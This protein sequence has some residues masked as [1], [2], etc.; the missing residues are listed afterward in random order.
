MSEGV[1]GGGLGMTWGLEWYS[2]NALNG[3]TRHLMWER[4][5]V[6]LL[7]LTRADARAYAVQ[8]Y[9]YIKTRPDLRREPHGWRLP[10]PVRVDLVKLP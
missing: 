8:R 10:R 7:F 4:P 3:E 5:L 6:P 1:S 9:G 2:R